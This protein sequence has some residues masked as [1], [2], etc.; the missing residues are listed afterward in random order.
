MKTKFRKPEE[1]SK[2][3]TQP[4]SARVTE[5]VMSVL[6]KEAKKNDLSVGTLVS[7]VLKDYVEWLRESRTRKKS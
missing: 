5:D 2:V 3:K 6:K 4:L 7:E 1:M